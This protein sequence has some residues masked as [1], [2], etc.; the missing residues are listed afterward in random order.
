MGNSRRCNLAFCEVACATLK[1]TYATSL[2]ACLVPLS[3]KDA[4][5]LTTQSTTSKHQD[6][7]LT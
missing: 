1:I 6:A 3:T 5:I 2:V 7:L 4:T